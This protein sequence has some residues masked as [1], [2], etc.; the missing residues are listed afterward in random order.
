MKLRKILVYGLISGLLS[1]SS[2]ST[3]K[4]MS[5][6]YTFKT[7]CI[8]TELDGSQSLIAWGNGGAKSDAIEN[9]KKKAVRDVLFQGINEG[10]S[11]CNLVPIILEVNA[12]KKYEAYFN[13]FFG[14]NGDYKGFVSVKKELKSIK[15]S[16]DKSVTYEL[17]VSVLRAE[18]KQKMISDGILKN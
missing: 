6:N 13:K 14:N 18:L 12:Q 15:V 7:E 4:T 5:G 10:K 2:C 17:E 11:D 3:P 16:V 1:F 9:A 8:R